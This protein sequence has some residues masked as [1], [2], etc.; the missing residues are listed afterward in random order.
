MFSNHQLQ[1]MEIMGA[2]N[3][4]CVFKFSPMKDFQPHIVYFLS[5]FSDE[6]KFK[7]GREIPQLTPNMTPLYVRTGE[8]ISEEVVGRVVVLRLHVIRA[9]CSE[10]LLA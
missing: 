8:M 2:Q 6:L 4:N 7:R 1:I 3:F 9:H 5:K 10:I